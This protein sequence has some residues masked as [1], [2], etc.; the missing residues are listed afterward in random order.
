ML[1]P[2]KD[3]YPSSGSSMCTRSHCS[4]QGDKIGVETSVG[5][6]LLRKRCKRPAVP[7]LPEQERV[8]GRVCPHGKS[9]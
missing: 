8:T 9:T 2:S 5:Q 3:L 6:V 7:R 4:P 1:E